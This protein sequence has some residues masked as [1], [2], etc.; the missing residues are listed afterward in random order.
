M[1][2]LIYAFICIT[3]L[4]SCNREKRYS[5]KLMKGETWEV[6]SIT[7]DGQE[8][9]LAGSKW[10]VT[11]DV[12]IYDSVPRV[13]WT[14]NGEDAVFEWQF[15]DKGKQFILSYYQLCEECE[16][17]DMDALDYAAYDLTGT[18]SVER[19]GRNKMEFKSNTTIGYPDKEVV[20][21]IER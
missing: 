14:S 16:G 20:I 2:Q 19:H 5:R 18:Y 9:P 13:M 10:L 12:D 3:L 1:K 11:C 7:A 17:V 21:V 15:R 4:V 8:T 6:V